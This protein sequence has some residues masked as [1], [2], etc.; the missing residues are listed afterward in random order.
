[1]TMHMEF[2][3]TARDT[4]TAAALHEYTIRRLSF[5]VRRF[6][7]RV[8]HVTIRLVDLNGPRR[9]VDTRCSMVAE[10][11]DGARLFVA[12]TA[13][14]P[15]A[16]ITLAAGRLT[17]ALRRHADR[18]HAARRRGSA[19]ASRFGRLQPRRTR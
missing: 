3:A 10:L 8:R 16:A 9:G 18:Q 1:M 13:A 5:A 11:M 19:G 7:H 4:A 6:R 17:E 2:F 15:F 12:A 14:W